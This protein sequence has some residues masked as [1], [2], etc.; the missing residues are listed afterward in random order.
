MYQTRLLEEA[1]ADALNLRRLLESA[2]PGFSNAEG[3]QRPSNLIDFWMCA[4]RAML[5][6]FEFL[7]ARSSAQFTLSV[8]HTLVGLPDRSLGTGNSLLQT[9][10]VKCVS[11][12]CAPRFRA[13]SSA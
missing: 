11:F 9:H 5:E 13:I 8:S 4:V 2:G 12:A 6:H 3:Q 7:E 1:I 10:Q